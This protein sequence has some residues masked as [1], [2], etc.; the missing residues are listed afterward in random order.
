MGDELLSNTNTAPPP[1]KFLGASQ[2]A[3]T[4]GCCVSQ[5]RVGPFNKPSRPP[6]LQPLP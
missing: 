3:N 4:C 5:C 6:L 2:N 1:P